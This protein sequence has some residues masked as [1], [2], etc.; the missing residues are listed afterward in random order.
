MTSKRITILLN[1]LSR[2]TT[3]TATH[4]IISTNSTNKLNTFTSARSLMS[5]SRR[6]SLE[7]FFDDPKNFGA[8][9]VKSGRPWR[10]DELRLKS[11]SDLHKLWFV[12]YKERNMLYTMKEAA[13]D[14]SET[15]PSPERIDK[16]EES[17]ANLE[18][19]VRERNKAY[20]QLEVSPCA[21]GERLAV[22][23]RD[24]LG[25]P[26]WHKCS[27]HIVPYHRNSKFRNSQGPGKQSETESFF[28]HYKEMQRKRYNAI[29]SRT[30]R[31]IRH[32]LRRFPNSDLDYLAEKHPEFPP[33]Y[34]KHLKENL[35]LYDDPPLNAVEMNV[36][37]SAKE[38][39][40]YHE[41]KLLQ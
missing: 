20:W 5:S 34:M 16:V 7:E 23:R 13:K 1:V 39:N 40:F 37:K 38:L 4:N 32:L 35:A 29:R 25:I 27:Q 26:R 22:F 24:V 36:K 41:P 6:Y 15:F 33:G 8:T 14:E 10:I 9:T 17:M 2:T 3:P 31:N 12:L 18:N 28:N 19:V 30:A 21:T 11:N